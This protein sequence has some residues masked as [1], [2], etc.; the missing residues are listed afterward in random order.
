VPFGERRV[1][2]VP[3]DA[4]F[5]PGLDQE[6]ASKWM[7]TPTGR[8]AL[9]LWG[10]AMQPPPRCARS[11]RSPDHRFDAAAFAAGGNA[12]KP[13]ILGIGATDGLD[14]SAA[15]LTFP[16]MKPR[17]KDSVGFS[18]AFLARI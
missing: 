9:Q 7:T 5:E 12:C 3:G 14:L 11:K 16:V 8:P 13:R 18:C 4:G 6:L 2:V 1:G 15:P 17:S 10:P